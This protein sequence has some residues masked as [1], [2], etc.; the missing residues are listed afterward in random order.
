[1][2]KLGIEPRL[3]EYIPGALPTELPSCKASWRCGLETERF[4]SHDTCP[5]ALEPSALER[6]ASFLPIFPL[7]CSSSLATALY[8][9]ADP[10]RAHLANSSQT[11]RARHPRV[12]V[13]RDAWTILSGTLRIELAGTEV[14]RHY[15]PLIFP[16]LLLLHSPL[17]YLAALSSASRP[18][19]RLIFQCHIPYLFIQPTRF[20]PYDAARY[21]AGRI[22]THSTCLFRPRSV[23]YL[24]WN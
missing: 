13:E 11:P 19:S 17:F 2:A 7:H 9:T 10:S 5:S 24:A 21:V 4:R 15:I 18:L 6:N 12:A 23:L 14:V 3:P 1:M 8:S 20:P 22:F 16:C